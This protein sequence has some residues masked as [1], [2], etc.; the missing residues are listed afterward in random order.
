MADGADGVQERLFVL[1][2]NNETECVA[3]TVDTERDL[4]LGLRVKLPLPLAVERSDGDKVRDVC[5]A[6]VDEPV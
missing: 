4:A 1:E 2:G 6:R 5:V 3:V